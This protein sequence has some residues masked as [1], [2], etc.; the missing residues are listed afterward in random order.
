MLCFM[1]PQITLS[2]DYANDTRKVNACVDPRDRILNVYLPLIP[3]EFTLYKQWFF[4]DEGTEIV[5]CFEVGE[6]DWADC[7]WEANYGN[8]FDS[9]PVDE[10]QVLVSHQII[11]ERN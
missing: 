10:I 7:R 3:R 9:F 8:P 2:P 11:R 4:N 6:T 1:L 5:P